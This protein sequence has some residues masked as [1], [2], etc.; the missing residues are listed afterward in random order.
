MREGEHEGVTG[1]KTNGKKS[2]KKREGAAL[3]KREKNRV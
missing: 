1:N 2:K 3:E